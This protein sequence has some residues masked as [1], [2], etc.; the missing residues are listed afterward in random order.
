MAD[1]FAGKAHVPKAFLEKSLGSLAAGMLGCVLQ[2]TAF[3]WVF[4][5]F[6]GSACRSC[7]AC[8]LTL[9]RSKACRGQK[10]QFLH[11]ACLSSLPP[12]ELSSARPA[13]G[14]ETKG[15]TS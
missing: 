5:Q 4:N 14:D 15:Q 8:L 3:F 2:V 7:M 10:T 9:L 6:L 13:V 1:A 12:K 11:C